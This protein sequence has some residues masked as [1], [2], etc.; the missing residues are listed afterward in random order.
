M[1]ERAQFIAQALAMVG[2][3]VAV[4]LGVCL[5]ALVLLRRRRRAR[6]VLAA[7]ALILAVVVVVQG[8]HGS[9]LGS[10]DQAR[11]GE[12]R[13][14]SWNTNQDDVDV[15]AIEALIEATEPDIVV[16]PEYF[17]PIAMTS[18]TE[19]TD[20]YA[21]VSAESSAATALI[22]HELG[23]YTVDVDGVPPWAGF[24]AV[25]SASSSPRLVVAHLQAP[26][27]TDVSLWNDHLEWAEGACS[28]HGDIA[29]GDFNATLA[30]LGGPKLGEC[31]DAAATL[32]ASATGTWPAWLPP[33]LGAQIDHVFAG[34]E[35]TPTRFTVLGG[36]SGS[37][38]RPI[39]VDLD[40]R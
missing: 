10:P 23:E 9:A 39:L 25:P 38:H 36:T 28:A 27:F 12:L 22:R 6:V 31:V 8:F 11:T 14:L 30:H 7:A 24:V 35:W 5:I 21:I 1:L 13:I 26:S 19:L 3:L 37:D 18:F 20:D 15:S 16:L 40:R 34:S 4:A 2:L 33:S 17:G 29:I 32:S